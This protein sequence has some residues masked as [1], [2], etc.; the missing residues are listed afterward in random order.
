M[1]TTVKKELNNVQEGTKQ[2]DPNTNLVRFH[3]TK[4]K[5]FFVGKNDFVGATLYNEVKIVFKQNDELEDETV[6]IVPVEELK[7][8]RDNVIKNVKRAFSILKAEDIKIFDCETELKEGK[9]N[10]ALTVVVPYSGRTYIIL[11]DI[12]RMIEKLNDDDERMVYRIREKN[13][14][15]ITVS[16]NHQDSDAVFLKGFVAVSNDKF[17]KI[18]GSET[19][20]NYIKCA[21]YINEGIG[22]NVKDLIVFN[23]YNISLNRVNV[24]DTKEEGTYIYSIPFKRSFK[25]IIYQVSDEDTKD[26]NKFMCHRNDVEI[27]LNLKTDVNEKT[28]RKTTMV[29]GAYIKNTVAKKELGSFKDIFFED[30][31]WLLT[32]N[33]YIR[34]DPKCFEAETFQ[35][36]IATIDDC[37]FSTFQKE[38][39]SEA[40]TSEEKPKKK[41]G[42]KKKDV[43]EESTFND[44]GSLSDVPE[45]KEESEA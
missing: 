29:T 6:G 2:R 41:G 26:P 37:I 28:G 22:Y 8:L 42:K 5:E 15:W 19:N 14:A 32:N 36:E 1:A 38:D 12:R 27:S 24:Y 34:F 43:K 23:R 4:A 21:T 40:T 7:K 25:Y 30:G 45:C 44:V 16:K 35:K 33:P 9:T 10:L 20:M 13:V 39:S 11:R 3:P 18:D 17:T 31:K